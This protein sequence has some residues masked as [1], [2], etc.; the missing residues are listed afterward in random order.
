[1]QE[2]LLGNVMHRWEKSQGN[3]GA[4]LYRRKEALSCHGRCYRDQF[5]VSFDDQRLVFAMNDHARI[6]VR[7]RTGYGAL[8]V[9]L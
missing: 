8:Q 6:Q 3:A 5:V 2:N 9:L 1:V 4:I 7:R